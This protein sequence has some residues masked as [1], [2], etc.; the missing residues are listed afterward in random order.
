MMGI[1]REGNNRAT[2]CEKKYW[3]SVFGKKNE[4]NK[5]YDKHTITINK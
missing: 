2:R 5:M 4:I 3:H 1:E